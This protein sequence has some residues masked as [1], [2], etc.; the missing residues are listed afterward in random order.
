MVE[1]GGFNP[2]QRLSC[3]QSRQ[4]LHTDLNHLR[5][6][7]AERASNVPLGTFIHD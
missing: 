5:T 1:A 2:N 4:F 6:A 3:F 7:R